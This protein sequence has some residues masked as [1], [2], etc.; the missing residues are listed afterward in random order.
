MRASDPPEPQAG[1]AHSTIRRRVLPNILAQ[2]R[3]RAGV[4]LC[5]LVSL[6]AVAGPVMTSVDPFALTGAALSAPSRAHLMGTDALGRDVLSGVLWGARASMAVALSVCLL[7]FA[8]GMFVGLLGGYSGGMIDAMLTWI[9]E[10]LQ[11]IPRFFLLIIAFAAFGTGLD[12]LVLTLGMTSWPTLAR[13]V[14][15]EVLRLR[16]ADFVTA[17][18]VGGATPRRVFYRTL[19][20]NVLPAALAVVGLLFGQAL[21]IE[22]SLGFL[23][24]GDPG[25]MS[26]GLQAAQAHAYLRQAWWL[27]FFPGFAISVAVLGVNLLADAAV[28][29]S[30]A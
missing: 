13:V 8:C 1:P 29:P 2:P 12:R 23:G 22:A 19:M 3:G 27:A 16:H 28:R 30:S 15:G 9:T 11:V 14:R 26:W 10:T 4:L 17:A 6:I 18:I 25:T 24:L 21:L 5:V 20:P 7:T